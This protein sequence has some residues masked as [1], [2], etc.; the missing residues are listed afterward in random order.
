[1]RRRPFSEQV[2]MA[3]ICDQCH[4]DIIGAGV[5]GE[6][7]AALKCLRK[8]LQAD[9]SKY[10]QVCTE[11]ERKKEEIEE[12]QSKLTLQIMKKDTKI[13]DFARKLEEKKG[14]TEEKRREV[15]EKDEETGVLRQKVRGKDE[16]MRTKQA[17]ISLI[18]SEIA[19]LSSQIQEQEANITQLTHRLQRQMN[20][21][22]ALSIFCPVCNPK[23]QHLMVGTEMDRSK[24][25]KARQP[26]SEA[27]KKCVCM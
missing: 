21:S 13:T 7:K 27:C 24:I 26:S 11:I 22:Q 25:R 3:R 19:Q 8:Q 2:T 20:K 18:T 14:K 23:F 9:L 4:K 6:K 12:N 10:E 5:K 1:M 17:E 16:E 15:R